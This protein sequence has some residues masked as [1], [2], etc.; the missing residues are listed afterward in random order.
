MGRRYDL[1]LVCA[2]AGVIVL[3]LRRWTDGSE[4]GRDMVRRWW[5]NDWAVVPRRTVMVTAPLSGAALIALGAAAL[6]PRLASAWIGSVAMLTVFVAMLL[7]YRDPPPFMPA[8]M[9]QEIDSGRLVPIR[10][11]WMDRLVFAF[12]LLLAIAGAIS[13]PVLIVVG[14]QA[15]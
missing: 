15:G 14:H 5:R 4:R 11:D 2:G 7:G 1:L 13:L 12:L 9:R 8:W 10:L 6:L 3:L